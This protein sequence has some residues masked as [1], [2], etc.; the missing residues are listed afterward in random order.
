MRFLRW[1]ACGMLVAAVITV[2]GLLFSGYRWHVVYEGS[3]SPTIPVES[4]VIIHKGHFHVGQ[5]ITFRA[6]GME[7]THRLVGFDGD[8][9]TITKGDAN[10]SVD[11]WH[12]PRSNIIGGVVSAQRKLGWLYVYLTRTTGG[13]LSVVLLIA[14]LWQAKR[15]FHPSPKPKHAA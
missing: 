12:V 4:M 2:G 5:V 9:N 3:M 15:V 6:N 11:P 7:V 13:M 8:G 14:C 10:S 1:V